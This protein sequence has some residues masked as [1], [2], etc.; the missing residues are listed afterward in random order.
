MRG[1]VAGALK[2]LRDQYDI[3]ADP[4]V[5]LTDLAEFMHFVTR[6]KIVPD[7]AA[8]ASVTE[9]ERSRGQAFTTLP[10][11]VLSRAWQMLTK[12]IGEV[13]A[14]PKPVAAAEM[15]LIRLAYAADLP[16]PDDALRLLAP[17]GGAAARAASTRPAAVRPARLEFGRFERGL[18]RQ[19]RAGR[20]AARR[21]LR[22]GPAGRHAQRA[23]GLDLPQARRAQAAAPAPTPR[24][25][26]GSP[27]SRIWSRSPPRS[28]TSR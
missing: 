11:R 12:G 16:T 22:R 23:A 21:A 13:Q 7:A 10:M 28:A 19:R 3:G 20:V 24:R 27:A 1:D 9:V 26:C 6:L 14:S 5:I 15:V 25:R 2:E 4:A 8:D 18:L 17:N